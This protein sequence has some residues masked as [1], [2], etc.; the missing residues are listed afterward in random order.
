MSDESGVR[1]T[2]IFFPV[3]VNETHTVVG[4]RDTGNMSMLIVDESLVPKTE[5]NYDESVLCSGAFDGQTKHRRPAAIVKVRS[6]HFGYTGNVLALSYR[7][8]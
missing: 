6:P 7:T 2:D 3:I 4:L 5:I 8:R 1:D